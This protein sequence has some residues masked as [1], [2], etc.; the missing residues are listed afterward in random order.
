MHRPA[1]FSGPAGTGMPRRRRLRPVSPGR[2]DNQSARAALGGGGWKPK[3]AAR[4]TMCPPGC[5]A[6]G[7][8]DRD[9]GLRHVI[10]TR[11]MCIACGRAH[12]VARAPHGTANPRSGIDS[13]PRYRT[14]AGGHAVPS[15]A[16]GSSF[17]IVARPKARTAGIS[18]AGV[19]LCHVAVSRSVQWLCQHAL[20][21]SD[22]VHA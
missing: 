10:V 9:P 8:F 12:R 14:R 21:N 3:R 11:R 16:R 15:V 2:T 17:P 13:T 18:P 4:R 5:S 19:R 22:P 7:R 6:F 1:A 20:R